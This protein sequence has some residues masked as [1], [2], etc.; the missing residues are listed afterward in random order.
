MAVPGYQDR[1][2]DFVNNGKLLVIAESR[3]FGY[4]QPGAGEGGH[5]TVIKKVP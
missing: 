1:I 5:A 4:K 2:K 3:L